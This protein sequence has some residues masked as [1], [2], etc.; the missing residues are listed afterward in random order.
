MAIK[1]GCGVGVRQAHS[2]PSLSK[3]ETVRDR[4]WVWGHP[5]EA[6]NESFIKDLA[7][8]STVEPVTAAVA[9]PLAGVL[10]D[11][12]GRTNRWGYAVT[13][14][15]AFLFGIL[16]VIIHSWVAN[17][18]MVRTKEKVRLMPLLREPWLHAGF[19]SLITLRTIIVFGDYLVGPFAFMYLVEELGIGPSQSCILA[20]VLVISQA[21]CYSLWRRIGD[22]VGYRTVCLLGIALNGITMF[23]GGSCHNMT[24][25]HSLPCLC[26]R[27]S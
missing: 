25:S 14:G 24:S 3:G 2:A 6:Y 8:K 9:L 11:A 4:I 7:K 26:A 1:T 27:G 13:F 23:Y 12:F 16:D 22:R 21:L 19:R 18:P 5:A 15:L 20:T 10:L 17:R